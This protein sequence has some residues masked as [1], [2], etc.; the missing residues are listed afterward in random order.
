[1]LALVLTACGAD[2]KPAPKNAAEAAPVSTPA[3]ETVPEPEPEE[4]AVELIPD[5]DVVGCEDELSSLYSDA[6][7]S[8]STLVHSPIQA[9]VGFDGIGVYDNPELTGEPVTKLDKGA[10]IVITGNAPNSLRIKNEYYRTYISVYQV[11]SDDTEGFVRGDSLIRLDEPPINN[12]IIRN[13]VGCFHFTPSDSNVPVEMFWLML[14]DGDY[15][16]IGANPG[17]CFENEFSFSPSD[18]YVF[19]TISYDNE[20][21]GYRRSRIYSTEGELVLDSDWKY[22]SPAWLGDNR[23]LLRGVEGNDA[24]YLFDTGTREITAFFDYTGSSTIED[25]GGDCYVTYP[26][27]EYNAAEGTLKMEFVRP[28][29]IRENGWPMDEVLDITTD[30]DGNVL[31]IEKQLE[32]W[33]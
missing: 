29:G 33:G 3:P 8:R 2:E 32:P 24:V 16:L 30:L 27:P 15:M 12:L 6:K 23:V 18:R 31:K 11:N 21:T 4:P 25:L 5:C 28:S 20:L 1:M 9:I 7:L 17:I 13:S 26:P 19:S 14:P 22:D 10:D